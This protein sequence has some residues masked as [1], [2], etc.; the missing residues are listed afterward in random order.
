[1]AEDTEQPPQ[2]VV[3]SVCVICVSL[4]C[5]GAHGGQRPALDPPELK[6]QTVDFGA[7]LGTLAPL[8]G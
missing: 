6:L 3:V 8:E 4:V 7:G 2:C 1:M 5:A